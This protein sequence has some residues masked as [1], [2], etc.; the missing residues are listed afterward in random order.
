MAP[1]SYRCENITVRADV[2][3]THNP[4][5]GA[6]RGFGSPQAHFALE[7][8]IDM[9]AHKLGIDPLEFRR[10]NILKPGDTMVTQVKVDDCA[11]SLPECLRISEEAVRR[12]RAI[13]AAPGRGSR[14]RDGAPPSQSM[15]LGAKVLDESAQR[16]EWLPDGRVL[17]HLGA[18]DLGQGLAAVGE[19]MVAEALGLNFEDIVT[20]PLDTWT[21]PNGGVTCGFSHDLPGGECPA[22]CFGW[23]EAGLAEAGGDSA[24]PAG[25]ESAV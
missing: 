13:P 6:M 16:L 2:V 24:W 15:G 21:T 4:Y 19:Q 7:S 5:A 9:L 23:V 20:D 11:A 8:C 17:I 25:E 1:G 12:M 14:G 18:P 3:Y 10:R 22:G